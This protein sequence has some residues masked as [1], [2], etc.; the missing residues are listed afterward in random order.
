MPRK[1]RYSRSLFINC[2]FDAEYQPLFRALVFAVEYCGFRA[3]CSL[4]SDDAGETRIGKIQRLIRDSQFAIHDLSRIESNEAGLPRFNMPFEFG[5]FL[6]YKWAGDRLQS[7][8]RT[9]VLVHE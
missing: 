7:R 1:V 8:K 3:R 2:P 6:G 9:L 5:L 4:E